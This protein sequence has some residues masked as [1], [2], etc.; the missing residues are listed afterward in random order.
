MIFVVLVGAVMIG[1]TLRLIGSGGSI[2][3]VP[4]LVLLLQHPEKSAIAESLAILTLIG[5]AGAF[6]AWRRDQ[7]DWK[8]FFFFGLPG[9]I[10]AGLGAHFSSFLSGSFQLIL[11][12]LLMFVVAG[13]IFLFPVPYSQLVFSK[14]A[15]TP[16]I[17]STIGKG[18]LIGGLT[19]LMG[20]GGGFLI[21]P[22]L[23][24]FNHLSMAA[25]V[26][27]SLAIIS[28]NAFIG[29]MTQLYYLPDI[30]QEISI[31]V[32]AIFSIAGILGSVL[33]HAYAKSIPD[34]HLKWIF[35]ISVLLIGIYLFFSSFMN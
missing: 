31:E 6:S 32:I 13:M 8:S 11:F 14:D 26:G 5:L 21:V 2:L 9:M 3:T 12:S 17:S 4:L 16:S 29:L 19:G 22:S 10:G 28:L 30:H 18:T 25:A 24:F 33:G 1:L 27:T 23:L 7:I 20:V 15:K 35:G 34:Q